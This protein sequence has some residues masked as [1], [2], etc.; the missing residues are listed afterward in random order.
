MYPDA[1]IP[2]IELSIDHYKSPQWHYELA[3]EISS[4]R[5]KGVLILGSGNIVHNLSIMNWDDPY[6]IYDWAEEMNENMK[7][8]ITRNNHKDLVNYTSL[9]KS[10]SLA[11]PTPEHY[12]P[13]LYILGLKEENEQIEFFNDKT[14]M[15]S[16][17]MTSVKVSSQSNI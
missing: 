7:M 6:G 16:I 1:D 14:V 10:A 9:G 2:V 8:L 15:G 17:S 11:I 5:K 4:L 3:K 13:L 12:I